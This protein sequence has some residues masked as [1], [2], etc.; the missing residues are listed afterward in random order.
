MTTKFSYFVAATL[1]TGLLLLFVSFHKTRDA[2][3]ATPYSQGNNSRDLP[4]LDFEA[5]GATPKPKERRQKGDHFKGRGNPGRRRPI[6]ELPEGVEPLPTNTHWWIGL[7][8]LP[9][10][11]S[12]LVVMGNI[13]NREAHL[14]DDRTGIYSEFT[15]LVSDVFKDTSKA[16]AAGVSIAVNRVGGGVRF[17]SGRTQTYSVSGQGMPHAGAQYVLFLQKSPEGDMVI[18]TGYELLYGRV[19]PLDGEE[20]HDPRKALPFAKYRGVDQTAFLKVIRD[21]TG[22]LTGDAK[23]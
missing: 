20:D 7:S 12:D 19:V 18:L 11:Q 16:I 9:M 21:T 23:Q 3:S 8:A 17:R 2:L 1:L 22:S 4:V 14:S 13:T 5:E 6:D 10:D 15:V